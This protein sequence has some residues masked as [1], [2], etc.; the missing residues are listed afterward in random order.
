MKS[1]ILFF[2][3]GFSVS[4][5]ADI[6]GA[7]GTVGT[8]EE[9]TFI[10]A[11]AKASTSELAAKNARINLAKQASDIC[12]KAKAAKF[13]I[14]NEK[15]IAVDGAAQVAGDLS[16]LNKTDSGVYWSVAIPDEALK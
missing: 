10:R 13:S 8:A 14:Q 11:T 16:C 7:V 12:T 3:L 2:V 5:L 6:V 15:L 1:L 9:V 4:G